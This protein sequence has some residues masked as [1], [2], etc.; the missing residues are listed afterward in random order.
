MGNEF[1]LSILIVAWYSTSTMQNIWS[2]KVLKRFPHPMT[3]TLCQFGSIALVM[4]VLMQAWNKRQRPFT[5]QQWIGGILPLMLLKLFSSF[6]GFMTLLKVPVSY[7]H[8]VKALMPL[9]TVGFSKVILRTSYS[10][11]IYMSLIPIVLGVIVTS[12][13]QLEFNLLGLVSALLSC[14]SLSLQSIFSKKVM[15]GIDHLNLLLGT[16]Q[17][18]FL[19]FLP[20]WF[21][22]E[23]YSMMFGSALARH[24]FMEFHEVMFELLG[25]SLCNCAQTIIAF[26]FLSL[27]QPVSY[28]VANV[29]K[30]IVVIGG[31]MVY[32]GNLS[33]PSNLFGMF[34][35]I[36]GVAWYNK[37]KLDETKK[38][39]KPVLPTKV[40]KSTWM[41]M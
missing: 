6:S 4:P 39:T 29:S 19:F 41:E 8:T 5:R 28:S 22:Y 17:V 12:A 25:A 2:K 21:F 27:V 18:C 16:T 15:K 1:K 24:T 35:A 33:S 31:S 13:T 30:R 9:F 32:F 3:L 7:A 40:P 11:Q 20:V 36:C 23:G 14:C 37:V 38:N 10:W 26:T 34:M